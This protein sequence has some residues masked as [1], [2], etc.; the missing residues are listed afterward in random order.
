MRS[1][2]SH[3]RSGP[4]AGEF[5]Q[6]RKCGFSCLWPAYELFVLRSIVS[7]NARNAPPRYPRRKEV[8]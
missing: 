5:E 6:L 8:R 3:G 7:E 1:N 4:D 2:F